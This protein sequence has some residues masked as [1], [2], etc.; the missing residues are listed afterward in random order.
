MVSFASAGATGSSFTYVVT[1]DNNIILGL[2]EGN[3][4]NFETAGLGNCRVWGLAY[5][6]NITAVVGDDAAVVDLASGCFALSSNF[7][8]VVRQVP[9]GGSVSTADGA[10]EAATCP[11]DGVADLIM[12]NSL[13]AVGGNFVYVVTDTNNVIIGLPTGNEVDFE[14]AGVGLC[15]VWGLTYQG[16]LLA[17]LGDTASNALLSSSCF[18]LSDNFVTIVRTVPAGGTVATAAGETDIVL[19]AGDGLQDSVLFTGVGSTGSNFTFVVTD[20]DNVIIGLPAG[21]FVN[22]ESAGLGVCR[23]WGLSFEGNILAQI[24][25]NAATVRLADGCFSLSDNFVTVNRIEAAGGTVATAEGDV[26][27]T[28]CPGDFNP[29]VFTFISTGAS[30][31]RFTFVVT[32]DN[33]LILGLPSG[34]SIDFDASGAGN[35]RVWGLS[36]AGE[37]TAQIGDN[38]AEVDLA[39]GCE[40]L[41]S[42]FVTVIRNAPEAGTI[43]LEGSGTLTRVCPGDGVPDLVRVDSAGNTLANYTYVITDSSNVILRLIP[44]YGCLQF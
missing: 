16:E 12:F 26:E 35:C 37:I 10:T 19:C 2:P 39:T 17:M 20:A 38:A 1:D 14:N 18:A 30:G 7:V 41:S 15:R 40:S 24:G 5:E 34:S 29:D 9:N 36:Y 25:D 21:D 22:F 27:V 13:G 4:V 6:G 11:G 23:V 28:T 44:F 42:N 43:S 33:N 8:T 32:D 3:T 31:P